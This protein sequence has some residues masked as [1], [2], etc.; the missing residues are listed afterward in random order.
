MTKYLSENFKS[1]LTNP[2]LL[3]WSILFIEFW[4]V[5]SFYVFGNTIPPIV[6]VVRVYMATVYGNL[7]MLSIST[8]ATGVTMSL[9]YASRS[10]RYITKY[11]RLSP[12]R[13]I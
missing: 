6:E 7:L 11:T 5:L 9:L 3:F 8:A 2:Y 1:M 4:V 13:F 10:I 12:S